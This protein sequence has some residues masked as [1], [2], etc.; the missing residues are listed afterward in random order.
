MA[1]PCTWV[2]SAARNSRDEWGLTNFA[3]VSK[4]SP[5]QFKAAGTGTPQSKVNQSLTHLELFRGV[6]RIALISVG[7]RGSPF[8]NESSHPGPYPSPG[9][10]PV[11]SLSGFN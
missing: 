1:R 3:L 8:R 5:V 2:S 9:R 7:H 10:E 6:L 4:L 11:I